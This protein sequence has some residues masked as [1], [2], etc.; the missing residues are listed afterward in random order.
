M[1]DAVLGVCRKWA[2]IE[3]GR[4]ALEKLIESG[5]NCAAAL[6]CMRNIYSA[7]DCH[8]SEQHL[9]VGTLGGAV[10][11]PLGWGCE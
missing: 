9:A 7:A 6:A 5:A 10:K 2:N 4:W 1:L 8:A 11:N 3:L